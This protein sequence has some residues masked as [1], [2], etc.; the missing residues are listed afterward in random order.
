[1]EFRGRNV[2][3]LGM[4]GV[5]ITVILAF[6]LN[7]NIQVKDTRSEAAREATTKPAN[8]ADFKVLQ[9]GRGNLADIVLSKAGTPNALTQFASVPDSADRHTLVVFADANAIKK[10]D[11][12]FIGR[13]NKLAQVDRAPIFMATEDKKAMRDMAYILGIKAPVSE[14]TI[15][16]GYWLVPPGAMCE[17]DPGVYNSCSGAPLEMVVSES[18]DPQWAKEHPAEAALVKQQHRE[19]IA[20]EMLQWL[21]QVQ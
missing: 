2:V 4:A 10:D 15:A 8:I 19:A 11:A 5:A 1:M 12:V 3:F 16:I 6:T 17:T 14:D 13:V 18:T 9:V 20:K 21:G 7:V